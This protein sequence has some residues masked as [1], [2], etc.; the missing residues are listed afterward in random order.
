LFIFERPSMPTSAAFFWSCSFVWSSYFEAL[1]PFLDG[2]PPPA[3][4]FAMRAAF[5]LLAPDLRT[6]S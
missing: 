1:P 6:F 5:S 2:L 3:F 4:A